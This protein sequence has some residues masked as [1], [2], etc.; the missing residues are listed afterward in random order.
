[1]KHRFRLA[2]GGQPSREK[3]KK[4][5]PAKT[6]FSHIDGKHPLRECISGGYLDYYARTR[7][8]GQLVYFNFDLA[9][10]MGLWD[11]SEPH[12]LTPQLCKDFVSQF[13]LMIINEYDQVHHTPI[14]KN[15]V[16]PHPFM[17]T[18]YL[19]LQHQS[20]T[21]KTSG[22]GRSVWNGFSEHRSVTWDISSVGTG[23]TALSPGA[24]AA[25]KPLQNGDESYSYGCGMADTDEALEAA[26]Q[27]E[28]FHRQGI[29][30]ERV[31]GI[32]S[33]PNGNAI[34]VRAATNLLRPAHF[35]LHLKQNNLSILRKL[36][37]YAFD[38]QV[39]NG[40]WKRGYG[41][42]EDQFLHRVT[43]SFARAAAL[44]EDHY[45]FCWM[46]WDGDNILL[47]GGILDY[48]SV[49][50]LGLFH[51]RYR[52]DDVD[53]YSTTLSEQRAKARY[54]VQTFAQLIDYVKTGRKKPLERFRDHLATRRFD[55]V[56]EQLRFELLLKRVGFS[57]SQ[58]EELLRNYLPLVHE[59]I[60]AYSQLERATSP[61]G[62]V[63]V[64]DGINSN[65]LFA[66]KDLL[67]ELPKL[68]HQKWQYVDDKHFM[69]IIRSSYANDRNAPLTESRRRQF[70][71]FQEAY[72][73]LVEA[74]T[75]GETP[76]R[77][78]LEMTMRASL[79]NKNN[80]I[81]GDAVIF[82]CEK[83][84]S[85]KKKLPAQV[86]QETIE[87]FIHHHTLKKSAPTPKERRVRKAV[88]T[89]IGLVR[90]YRHSL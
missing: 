18:R 64:G 1:M 24:V 58:R 80:A 6:P 34:I 81:T 26:L 48:G 65:A 46:D 28:I 71:D 90:T 79:V 5:A 60:H 43:E 22:D 15:Q 2:H 16:K 89:M 33:Y 45:I 62:P 10:E 52:Y 72:M 47:D 40:T 12:K 70:R 35:F 29:A 63:R 75:S 88:D 53:R 3:R 68:Y 78:L 8:G 9:A 85:W 37:A 56:F 57:E 86:I 82:I 73:S 84:N 25:S 83:L 14:P 55:E 4:P 36:V 87:H 31:L 42:T 27:S 38:R 20:R 61:F 30:T 67:R 74:V 19:Q 76:N 32:I 44:F 59:F 7:P 23:V 21:G 50:Q 69:S 77:T 54:I 13:G 17:A 39:S 51:H 49:R 41:S 66:M 11:R